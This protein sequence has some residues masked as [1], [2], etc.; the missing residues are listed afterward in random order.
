MRAE[1]DGALGAPSAPF[2]RLYVEGTCI[3]GAL[4]VWHSSCA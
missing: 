2:E 1:R 3:S 4:E